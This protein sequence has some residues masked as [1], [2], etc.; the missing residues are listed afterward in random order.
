M[1][2]HTVYIPTFLPA[3]RARFDNGEDKDALKRELLKMDWIT[4][5]L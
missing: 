1:T 2:A 4:T 5:D 3:Y